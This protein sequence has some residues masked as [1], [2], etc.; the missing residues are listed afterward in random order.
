MLGFD[1]QQWI[2]KRAA[3]AAARLLEIREALG[4]LRN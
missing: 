2:R 3:A 4:Q 1:Q